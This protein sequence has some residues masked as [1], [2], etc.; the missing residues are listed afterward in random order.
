MLSCRLLCVDKFWTEAGAAG[1]CDGKA[2]EDGFLRLL[3][4][5]VSEKAGEAARCDKAG[6]FVF[7]LRCD[8]LDP[9]TEV[10]REGNFWRYG[11]WLAAS[12][13]LRAYFSWHAS[14]R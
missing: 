13:A 5:L 3:L 6:L 12:S 11:V 14:Q 10:G 1:K 7:S 2:L 8:A 9:S 4:L